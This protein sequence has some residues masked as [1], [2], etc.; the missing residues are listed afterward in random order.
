MVVYNI[1]YLSGYSFANRC[2]FP[3]HP[4][5]KG[6][7]TFR[8]KRWGSWSL[9]VACFGSCL[10]A[11]NAPSAQAQSS[12][13]LHA[14][15]GLTAA[16]VLRDI[17]GDTLQVRV[18]SKNE[19]VRMLL[20]DAP[21]EVAPNKPI[22]PFAREA[23]NYA[24]RLLP[25]GR[26]IWLQVGRP[27][28]TRDKYGRLLAYV[29][30]SNTDLFN[31][32]IVDQG[33]A[34]IAYVNPPN[35]DY[36]AQ[37][38]AAQNDAKSHHRGIWSIPG[39]VTAQGF[40]V[41]AANRWLQTQSRS[42]E[43]A[44]GAQ[45]A[46]SPGSLGNAGPSVTS[47]STSATSG[48]A[49]TTAADSSTSAG[50]E[51][52]GSSPS[53]MGGVGSSSSGEISGTS[54]GRSSD[55]GSNASPGQSQSLTVVSSNLNVQRGGYASVTIQTAP[56]ALGTIEVDYKTGPSHASG[57]EPKTADSS[58]LITWQW[59]VGSSTTPGQWPVIISANGQTVTLT[60]SV[61]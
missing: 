50:G 38:N 57:L 8:M 6:G 33:L 9:A 58:G 30:L 48:G 16:T 2:L 5:Y 21:E 13:V 47:P 25:P 28:H 31:W 34:R 18:G 4:S 15:K 45:A 32:D 49:P 24:E 59:R 1:A 29:W 20:I 43:N 17:D 46:Q 42:Q 10:F 14:P 37:L 35:T 60:L 23:A 56:G 51:S 40:N 27:G 55:E 52:F 3:S 44:G 36:L 53:D 19:T 22:E 11:A 61:S 26:R 54:T 12:A 7:D 39:Y 41:D